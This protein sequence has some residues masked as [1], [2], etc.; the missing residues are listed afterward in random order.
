M[1][2][3]YKKTYKLWAAFFA[4]ATALTMNTSATLA[5]NENAPPPVTHHPTSTIAV[6]PQQPHIQGGVPGTIQSGQTGVIEPL[7]TPHPQDPVAPERDLESRTSPNM[8]EHPPA[9]PG[10]SP[11]QTGQPTM[12]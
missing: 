2:S 4:L 12:P 5:Q 7:H 6:P 1:K 3:K 9:T 10:Q 11:A 8:H